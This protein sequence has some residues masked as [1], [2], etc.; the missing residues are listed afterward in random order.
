MN[1]LKIV[2]DELPENCNDCSY[3]N[4]H[5]CGRARRTYCYALPSLEEEIQDEYVRPDWCPL[6]VD[7]PEVCEWV[8]ISRRY[9]WFVG[10]ETTY[11]LTQHPSMLVDQKDINYMFV[12]CPYCGK[13]IKYVKREE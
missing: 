1:V 7:V 9:S 3:Y 6:V 13:R 12:H 11:E 10:W 8:Q 2:V 5:Y 4:I